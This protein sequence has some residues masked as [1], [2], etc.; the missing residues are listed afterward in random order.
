MESENMNQLT[1]PQGKK[2]VIGL[3]TGRSGTA[4]LTSLIDR[5]FGG[6]CFHEMNPAGS[7]FTGNPQPHL[8]ALREFTALLNGGERH[9]LA[10]DYSR[11]ASEQTYTRLQSMSELNVIGDIAFYYLSYVDEMLSLVPET[12]FVCIKRDRAQTI[13]SWFKKTSIGRWPSIWLGDRFK[14][15]VTRTPFYTAYNYWQE[16]DGSRWQKD[17]VWDSCFP[18]FEAASKEDAIG[19]YW[20]FYYEEAHRLQAKHPDSFRIFSVEELNEFQGQKDILSF[21]GLPEERWVLGEDV[22]L[23][24]SPG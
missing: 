22:H 12:K 4:S 24:K 5:Q 1:L 10:I 19:M 6:L 16:H 17:P 2:I 14:A 21:I 9:C 15:L 11:P 8:N 7:V 13:A 20:D 3:G 23:H 18:K